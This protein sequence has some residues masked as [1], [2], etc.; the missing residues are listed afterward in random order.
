MKY[1]YLIAFV[2]ALA[3][4]YAVSQTQAPANPS[5]P[6][7]AQQQ[8]TSP[9][10]PASTIPDQPAPAQGDQDAP[11][12]AQDQSKDPSGAPATASSENASP[13]GD[14]ALQTQIQQQLA[15]QNF[16]A[17]IVNVKD[18]VATL[19]GSVP[20][21]ADRKR[22]KE[23]AK[24]VPGVKKVS[25]KLEVN[26][27]AAAASP[28]PQNTAGSIVGN[29][30][31]G[32]Q[33]PVT[34]STAPSTS[35]QTTGGVSGSAAST[36]GTSATVTGSGMPQSSTGTVAGNEQG[37]GT[38]AGAAAATESPDAAE[39]QSKIDGALKN[40]PTLSSSS[41]SVHVTAD[42]IELSGSVPTSKDKTTAQRIA[43][44]FAGNRKVVDK[45]TIGT[46]PSSNP[47]LNN[48]PK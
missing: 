12:T 43:Q 42:T 13:T 14:D 39:L 40:E 30:T 6:P 25:E 48:N 7:N 35:T 5:A 28:A 8:S 21:K 26:P 17:V 31:N 11:R 37:M 9:S 36:H 45:V 23:L 38:A 22:A 18:G 46:N 24:N 2:L 16:G 15:G 10:N 33:A 27:K 4:A 47:P 44:S 20:T 32:T 41:V 19:T 29:A 1:F 34:S 3:T